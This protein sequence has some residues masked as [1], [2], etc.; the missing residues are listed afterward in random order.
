MKQNFANMKQGSEDELAELK[1]ER[2]GLMEEDA[3]LMDCQKH[4]EEMTKLRMHNWDKK[5]DKFKDVRSKISEKVSV[6]NI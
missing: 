6:I 2:N 1:K 3:M 4:E 5:R